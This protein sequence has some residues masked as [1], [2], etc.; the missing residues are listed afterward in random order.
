M[1]SRQSLVNNDGWVGNPRLGRVDY[2][3]L[4]FLSC[5]LPAV[6]WENF[7]VLAMKPDG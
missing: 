6:D 2:C 3:T 4:I 1:L 7:V 5:R